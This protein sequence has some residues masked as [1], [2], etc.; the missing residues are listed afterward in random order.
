MGQERKNLQSTKHV[1]S[2]GEVEE[3]RYFYP[4]TEILKTRDICTTIIPFN[5][6]RKVFSDITDAF[7]HKSIRVNLHV[8]MMI[9]DY[10]SNTIIFELIKIRQ[11][12][13]IRNALLNIH[14]FLK[15]RG[16]DPKFYIMENECYSDLK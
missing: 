5:L 11:A 4:D 13:T 8:K 7:P 3:D 10:D 16:S 9:H 2:E 15:A 6:K 12:E 1:K 14:K